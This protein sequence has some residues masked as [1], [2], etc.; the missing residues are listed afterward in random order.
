MT[1]AYAPPAPPR[2]S[3]PRASPQGETLPDPANRK[4]EAGSRHP[5]GSQTTSASRTCATA[6]SW[7][8]SA[9]RTCANTPHAHATTLKNAALHRSS[10]WSRTPSKCL[11]PPCL[12][13]IGR[14]SKVRALRCT[15]ASLP[16]KRNRPSHRASRPCRLSAPPAHTSWT[17]LCVVAPAVRRH[18]HHCCASSPRLYVVIATTAV[19]RRT[20]RR[21]G[22]G[23]HNMVMTSSL[24]SSILER[25]V[26]TNAPL[27]RQ[28][29]VGPGGCQ[30]SR[31][32]G[33]AP[34]PAS[35]GM[36]ALRT[37]WGDQN[38]AT[39]HRKEQPSWRTR[40]HSTDF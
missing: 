31:M 13:R 32:S 14:T 7:A 34:C 38:G 23:H 40:N 4:T 28:T 8:T 22:H 19:R 12:H 11:P 2:A 24:L 20:T 6:A 17:R 25:H 9:S 21:G 18:R 1:A 16:S 15:I 36:D 27:A 5:T 39:K 37:A 10:D 29:F 3:Q 30:T 33:M 26:Q 35:D